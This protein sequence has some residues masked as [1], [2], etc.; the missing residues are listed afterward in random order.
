[1]KTFAISSFCWEILVNNTK[2]YTCFMCHVN[3][4]RFMVFYIETV[5]EL[6]ETIN[7]NLD[8]VCMNCALLHSIEDILQKL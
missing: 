6:S 1:M 5:S 7:K 2:K 8:F 3:T 4:T